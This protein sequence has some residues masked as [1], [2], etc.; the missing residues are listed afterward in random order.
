LLI[1]R[2]VPPFLIAALGACGPDTPAPASQETTAQQVRASFAG[3]ARR[4]AVA[5]RVPAAGGTITAY[6]VPSLVAFAGA[7]RAR[8][9]PIARI[10]GLDSES[11]YLFIRTVAREVL[12]V[13]LVTGRVDTIATGVERVTLGPDGTLF[14]VDAKRRVTS[15]KRRA[16]FVWPHAL[17]AAPR[18]LFGAADQR[19][20]A[21]LA[22]DPSRLVTAAAD[23]PLAS[24]PLPLAGDVAASPWGD[25]VATVA[26]SGVL[27]IDPIGSGTPSFVPLEG[28]PRALAFSPAGHRVYVAK[29]EGLGLAVIDRYERR[30]LDGL[31]L[32][33]AAASVRIDPLGRWLLAR[34]SAG[35]SAWIVD[36]P[37]KALRG[38]VFTSWQADLPAVGPDGSI[39]V[40]QG[41]DVVTIR[42]DSLRETG[43]A[44]GAA[45]DLWVLT[46]WRPPVSARGAADAVTAGA[47]DAAAGTDPLA[48]EGPLYVQVSVSQNQEWSRAA[49]QQ[50]V[51]AGLP[52]SVL[53]PEALDD[54]YRVVLGPY[55]TRVQA[56]AIGRKLGRP[57]WIYQPATP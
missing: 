26:D 55:P 14:T 3:A 1:S 43:R 13:D 25:L 27:L 54:G 44:R 45:D 31:A 11:E 5:I 6:A 42:P 35:D 15:L 7:I 56:E 37:V 4:P 32:P 51:L 57:Y 36:L 48:A 50:L 17:P 9:P 24:H 19:L 46:T 10:V 49:A 20:I 12:G 21:V 38:G 23:Q 53:P 2:C 28:H 41:P 8:V 29:R 52:A 18:D 47:A 16:R 40:R 30:E 34:P 33:G 39:V 22:Q